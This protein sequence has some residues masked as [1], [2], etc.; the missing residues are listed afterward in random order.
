[1]PMTAVQQDL[2]RRGATIFL[3]HGW[4]IKR[5]EFVALSASPCGYG[6]LR[7]EFG[8]WREYAA[9]CKAF[10]ETGAF[11]D[12]EP[13]EPE[14]TP[15][16]EYLVKQNEQ[17]QS[18]IDKLANINAVLTENV[19]AS[20]MK[21][22]FRASPVPQKEHR[23]PEDLEF[24]AMRSD[25]H[26][27]ELVDSSWV[28]G[29]SGYNT[30]MFIERN[31]RWLDKVRSF[32]EQDKRSLGLNKLV[33]YMLGDHVTGELIYSGQA[34]QIDLAAV[35][36][37]IVAVQEYVNTILALAKVF[38]QVE[39][40]T[41]IGNHGRMGKKGEG[42]PRSNLDYLLY[43]WMQERL[44]AQENVTVYVSE[45]PTM[46]VQNGQY[47]FALNHNDSVKGYQGIPYYG[48]ERKARRLSDLYGLQLHYKL[49][50]HFHTPANLNDE[51]L[52]NGTLV[53]GS[54]LSVN[55]MNV[56]T[57]PSQKIFYFDK[58]KGINRESNLYL[59][60]PVKLTPDEHGI[61][62]AVTV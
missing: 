41:V 48:L 40:F 59:A 23:T 4:D 37:L 62:T 19:I 47:N 26:V 20:L 3:E 44:R 46:I 22:S 51:T 18:R 49:G 13:S 45:S 55:R 39:V 34:Y 54:D 6:K 33:V 30:G 14:L 24:H 43:R 11:A 10:S 12:A 17:L 5:D 58:D 36:Q 7:E 9:A 32:R 8:S 42:H 2:I 38:P 56:A 1:M 57:R 16:Q 21:C 60:D 53:G 25:D 50:G 61:Y 15:G 35:D 28:Q 31:N 29:L 52:M 27:G